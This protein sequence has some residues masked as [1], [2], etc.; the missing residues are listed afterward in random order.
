MYMF[1]SNYYYYYL[2][3]LLYFTYLVTL[4][5]LLTH[6]LTYILTYLVT[7]FT[8]LY[9]LSHILT[10]L[11]THSLTYL[12]LLY[13]LTYLPLT[14]HASHCSTFHNICDVPS[15]AV[16]CCDCIECFPGTASKF[17]LK[18]L[19]TIPLAPIITSTIVH[20]RFHIVYT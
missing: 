3:T 7:Y 10:Y 18:L 14:L 11:I 6:L 2:H 19:V 1:I 17:F 8:L 16:F 20:F 15:T 13:L 12:A 5:Y 9:L 4:L